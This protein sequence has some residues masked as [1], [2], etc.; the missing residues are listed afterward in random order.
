MLEMATPSNDLVFDTLDDLKQGLAILKDKRDSDIRASTFIK[1]IIKF[2]YIYEVSFAWRNYQGDMEELKS[3]LNVKDINDFL[4]VYFDKV[5]VVGMRAVFLAKDFWLALVRAWV[6]K[7]MPQAIAD[8]NYGVMKAILKNIWNKDEMSEG[9]RAMMIDIVVDAWLTKSNEVNKITAKI[10]DEMLKSIEV[11]E[12]VL[13]ES[14]QEEEQDEQEEEEP[15]ATPEPPVDVLAEFRT[16]PVMFGPHL[17]WY[18]LHEREQEQDEESEST[19]KRKRD[20]SEILELK[21][22]VSTLNRLLEEKDKI[23]KDKDVV[24]ISLLKKIKVLES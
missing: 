12:E 13:D 1:T 3:S 7:G 8:I 17:P 9:Q 6:A 24:I 20:D 22:E 10:V 21:Q 5:D 18:M 16:G 19:R 23:I 11:P 4:G 15:V 2:K 14:M